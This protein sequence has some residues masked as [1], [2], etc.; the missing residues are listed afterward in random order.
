MSYILT[1]LAKI[2]LAIAG[3]LIFMLLAFSCTKN[4]PVCKICTEIEKTNVPYKDYP[5]VST[6]WL[7]D[8]QLNSIDTN[9]HSWYDHSYKITK[10]ITCR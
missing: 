8:D 9:E 10:K 7:C 4:D 3:F 6:Y 2:L 5:H 1:T